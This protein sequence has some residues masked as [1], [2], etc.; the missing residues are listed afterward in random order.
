MYKVDNAVIMAA[1]A[2]SRFAPLSYECP[3]ALIEVKGEILIE[4]QIHQLQE[5][6][7]REIYIVTGYKAEQFEYLRE[8]YGV[9]IVENKEYLTKNNHS[10][11][12]AVRD[13]LRNTYICSADNYFS[14][15][16]FESQVDDSYYAALYSDGP[17][18]EWCMQ[19]DANGYITDVRAGGSDA[20]YMLGH[21]FW[22]EEF[23]EKFKK[24]LVDIYDQPE[25]KG[26]FWEDI[27]I[28]NIADLP[29]RMRKYEDD[30]IFEFDSL[31]ELRLFDTSYV[32]DTR[33]SILKYIALRLGS[34]ERE[35]HRIVPMKT[36]DTNV[37]GIQ[38]EFGGERYGYTYSN[39]FLWRILE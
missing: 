31:D 19:T 6:G 4:R 9:H 7:I 11:I 22:S 18:N 38:F 35:L 29:M 16:P 3:K 17:T 13:I 24:I 8:K 26:L 20:W 5:A 27:F 12:Y 25:T 33:S 39:Q 10:S 21:A 23:S 34:S 1:G 28:N 36:T 15:N 14:K 32:E 30:V 2:S 37:L